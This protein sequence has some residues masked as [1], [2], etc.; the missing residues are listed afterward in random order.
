MSRSFGIIWPAVTG[1]NNQPPAIRSAEAQYKSR[2]ANVIQLPSRSIL[3]HPVSPLE[4]FDP[5]QSN[6]HRALMF[7]LPVSILLWGLIVAA[8]WLLVCAIR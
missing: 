2:A 5:P 4:R 7:A 8:V 6:L 3:A 1:G